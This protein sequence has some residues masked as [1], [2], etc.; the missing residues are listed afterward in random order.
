ML[1]DS[2]VMIGLSIIGIGIEHGGYGRGAWE[3]R[4]AQV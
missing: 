2:C 3:S 1:V 4:E